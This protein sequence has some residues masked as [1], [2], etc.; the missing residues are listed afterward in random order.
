MSG[1]NGGGFGG[2]LGGF[3]NVGFE[4]DVDEEELTEVVVSL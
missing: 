4:D 1:L 3:G 2:V